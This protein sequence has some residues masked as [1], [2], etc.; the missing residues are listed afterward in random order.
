[1]KNWPAQP[2]GHEIS[3]DLG[4]A[5]QRTKSLLDLTA[6]CVSRKTSVALLTGGAD[7][8]YAFGLATA[9]ISKG[10]VI[11]LIG[12]DDL[13][14]PD[15]H[16]RP[17]VTFLNLRGDQQSDAGFVRKASRVLIYYAKLIRYTATA[18]PRIFHILW[19]NKFEFF[20]RTVLMLYYKLLRKKIVL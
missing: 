16:G 6:P 5:Y 19:N 9:L 13:D 4:K 10:T 7:K 17:G 14:C 18:E 3:S 12:N 15:F 2:S 20:D 11:D 1:M 8:P